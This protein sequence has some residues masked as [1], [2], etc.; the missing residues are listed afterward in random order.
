MSN[1]LKLSQQRICVE[2]V[3]ESDAKELFE[4]RQQPRKSKQY[5]KLKAA[6]LTKKLWPRGSTIKIAFLEDGNNVPRT[7]L[8]QIEGSRDDE[9]QPLKMDPL[10]TSITPKNRNEKELSTIEGVKKIVAERIQPIAGLNIVFVDNIEES[11]IRI[12]FDPNGGAWS[13][14][15]TD[16]EAEQYRGQATMNL[17]WFDVATTIHE[18]G[19]ALGMVHE[20]QNPRGNLIKWNVPKVLEWA[21]VTQGWDPETTRHNIIDRYNADEINGSEFDPTSIMLYFFPGSLTLNDKGTH[22][23]LRLSKDD[24]LYINK[25]YPN[26][27]DTPSEFLQNAY[28]EKL[29][30]DNSSESNFLRN[31]VIVILIVGIVYYFYIQY[32]KKEENKFIES[33]FKMASRFGL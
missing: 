5:E 24:I 10:Q 32:K 17:G 2:K 4:M 1:I 30:N 21:S 27:K 26:S 7:P 12:S 33:T 3:K 29:S 15:G 16:C 13:L 6:F 8:L 28:D 22:Q 9:G 25:M 20:H 31:L 11:M 14:L 19:H 23:N 18:F